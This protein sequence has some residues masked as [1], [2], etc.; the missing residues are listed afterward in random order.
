MGLPGWTTKVL[1][2]GHTRLT[3][4]ETS[5]SVERGVGSLHYEA[6]QARSLPLRELRIAKR[7]ELEQWRAWERR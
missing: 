1:R 2:A 3:G 7:S 6:Q 4:C 5:A